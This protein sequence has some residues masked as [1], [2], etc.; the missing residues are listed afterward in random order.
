MKA[1]AVR[2]CNL[3]PFLS[4]RA[5]DIKRIHAEPE[6]ALENVR[7]SCRSKERSLPA[8]GESIERHCPIP[9]GHPYRKISEGLAPGDPLRTLGCWA[10]GAGNSWITLDEIVWEDG[11]VT[12]PQEDHRRW[13]QERCTALFSIRR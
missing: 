5:R 9:L 13:L 10:Y 2:I 11:S 1:K 8:W 3:I 12:H 7:E 4:G 6:K